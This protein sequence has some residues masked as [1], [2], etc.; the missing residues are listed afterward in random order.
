MSRAPHQSLVGTSVGLTCLAP[1][2][3]NLYHEFAVTSTQHED[4]MRMC[5]N[6]N[7]SFVYASLSIFWNEGAATDFG[8]KTSMQ[9]SEEAI[10]RGCGLVGAV[11]CERDW[12]HPLL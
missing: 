1:T 6:E 3:L 7:S 12:N 9:L 10:Q 4:D 8:H 11:H 2:Y 5:L